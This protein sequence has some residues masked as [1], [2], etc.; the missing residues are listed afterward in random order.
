VIAGTAGAVRHRQ[1]Q[2]WDQQAAQQQQADQAAMYEQQAAADQ[3]AAQAAAAQA[4]ATPQPGPGPRLDEQLREVADLHKSGV[5][6]DAE[7]AAA[8]AQLLGKG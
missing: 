3:A 2:R 7:F 4:A 1:E 8:K 5:L 6:T